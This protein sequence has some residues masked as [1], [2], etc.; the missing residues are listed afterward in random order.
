MQA[1]VRSQSRIFGVPE[2]LDFVIKEDKLPEKKKG[3]A[4]SNCIL[5]GSEDLSKRSYSALVSV[6][7]WA[8]ICGIFPAE[9]G[10]TKALNQKIKRLDFVI[11][12]D[13]LPE[14]KMGLA[15]S[16]CILRGNGDL[17]KR[18]YSALVSVRT[19]AEICCIF[20][21][22]TGFTKALNQKWKRL[23]FVIKEDKLSEKKAGKVV[24]WYLKYAG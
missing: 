9:T 15:P 3:L 8:E 19:W 2:T 11:K 7:T 12:E 14:K 18:S 23:D 22:E 1:S 20:P 16:N 10:F 24:I 21:V 6:R 4:P 5:R 13:K 17:S